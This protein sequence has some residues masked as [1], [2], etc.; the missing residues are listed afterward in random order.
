MVLG[1]ARKGLKVVYSTD[2]RPVKS[3]AEHARDTDLM[4]CEGM[5]GEDDKEA[6]SQGLP[7]YDNER[8]CTTGERGSA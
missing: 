5:Y 6:K 2:T 1:E 8:S 3:I 4:I 7:P